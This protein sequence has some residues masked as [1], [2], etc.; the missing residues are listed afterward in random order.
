MVI[1]AH[2]IGW[3]IIGLCAIRGCI[4]FQLGKIFLALLTA[5]IWIHTFGLADFIVT[6]GVGGMKW[7][8]NA[9][10]YLVILVSFFLLIA[11]IDSTLELKSGGIFGPGGFV[12]GFFGGIVGSF[13]YDIVKI[14]AATALAG[15]AGAVRFLR[16]LKNRP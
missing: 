5:T 1:A 15:I 16:G 10:F 6:H 9:E 11:C 12:S 14:L 8:E 3:F 7:E 2:G 13:F 4:L